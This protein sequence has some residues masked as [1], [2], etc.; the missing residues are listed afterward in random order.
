MN[1]WKSKLFKTTR[2]SAAKPQTLLWK[3][4]RLMGL[5]SVLCNTILASD[6]VA[7]N[8]GDDIVRFIGKPMGKTQ[9]RAAGAP[10]PYSLVEM[11]F[12]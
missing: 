9:M 2:Q 10:M 4:Q 5:T 3:V 8:A 11:P 7:F 1:C 6:T 12:A